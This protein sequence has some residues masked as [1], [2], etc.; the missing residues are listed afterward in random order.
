M[1]EILAETTGGNLLFQIARGRGNDAD[2][3]MDLGGA[4]CAL[5]RLIDQHAQDLVL[6]LARHVAD[7]IDEQRAAMRLF[8]CAG[9]ALLLAVGL[10][11]PE[12]FELH[13][14]RRDR[15]R[16]DDDEGPLRTA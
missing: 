6:G 13:A 1:I 11:D 5:E 16:V 2:V 4:A 12:Q 15:C 7:F 9:L 14:L 3:D 8:Q 10:F